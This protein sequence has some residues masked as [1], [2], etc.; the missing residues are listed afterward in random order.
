MSVPRVHPRGMAHQDET[1]LR[2]PAMP[3]ALRTPY[4]STWQR[5]DRLAGEWPQF[6]ADGITGLAGIVRVDG[7]AYTFAGDPGLADGT[8][9]PALPQTSAGLTATT[10][11]YGFSGGGVS[12]TVAFLSPVD[13][14]DLRR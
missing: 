7:Q 5:G 10:S 3:L 9:P 14:V 2:P 6:W 13:P 11:T 1:S 12:L 4:L 8:K